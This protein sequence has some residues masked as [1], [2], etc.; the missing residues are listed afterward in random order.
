MLIYSSIN[1]QVILYMELKVLAV[2]LRINHP[3]PPLCYVISPL[4]ATKDYG[5]AVEGSGLGSAK[6]VDWLDCPRAA[7]LDLPSGLPGGF[8]KSCFGRSGVAPVPL[9]AAVPT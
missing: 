6:I 5:W 8:R 4:V 2:T 9:R 3:I 1:A 7:R